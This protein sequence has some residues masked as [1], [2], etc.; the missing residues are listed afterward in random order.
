M[1]L[2]IQKA[3]GAGKDPPIPFRSTVP[4]SSTQEKLSLRNRQ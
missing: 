1:F 2:T 3:K 4:V